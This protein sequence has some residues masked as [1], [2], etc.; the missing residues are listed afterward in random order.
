MRRRLF[1]AVEIPEALRA[2]LAARLEGTVGLPALPGK[3]VP[4]GAFIPAAERYGL[5]HAVDRWVISAA[6]DFE[7]SP[8]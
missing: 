3:V 7:E 6:F 8:G 5:M 1:V 2:L 4:P